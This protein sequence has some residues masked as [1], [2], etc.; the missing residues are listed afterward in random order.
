MIFLL[1]SNQPSIWRDFSPGARGILARQC[2]RQCAAKVLLSLELELRRISYSRFALC[3][4]PFFWL[5]S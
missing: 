2:V 5:P 1:M 3:E 4:L